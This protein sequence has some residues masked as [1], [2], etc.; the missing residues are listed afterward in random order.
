MVPGL[1]GA[2]RVS[3][4]WLWS[5]HNEH[6]VP[7][8]RLVLLASLRLS[9]GDFRAGM[10]F[11]VV[12]L[13]SLALGMVLVAKRGASTWRETDAFFP[14]ALLHLGHHANLLWAWQAQFVLS[15]VLAGGFLLLIVWGPSWPGPRKMIVAGVLLAGL[16]LCGANGLAL[17]PALSLWL[18]ASAAAQLIRRAPGGRRAGF[19]I[20]GVTAIAILPA[21][22][23]FWGYRAA[24][25]HAI[26]GGIA[27][28]L[29]TALQFL[30]LMLGPSATRLWPYSGLVVALLF[31]ASVGLLIGVV[32][33]RPTE[34]PRAL[35]LLAFLGGLSSLAVG[36]GWGRAGSSVLAGFEPRYVTLA[37]PLGCPLLLHLGPLRRHAGPEAAGPAR[38]AGDD[39]GRPLAERPGR[40]Q[41]GGKLAEAATRLERDVRSGM[42]STWSSS[43]PRPS[44]TRP[45]MS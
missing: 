10:I 21:A 5:Q 39:A 25:H 8:P 6:R 22:L 27:A 38:P 29:T 16:P 33:R 31:V 12:A 24:G 18:L 26:E 36:L 1:T 14:L 44:C 3:M 7:L 17:A 40:N 35:G 11:N 2:R 4:E 45:R 41:C 9:A 23:Y 19:L 37:S 20:L 28:T 15:T 42:P 13:G 34:R 30:S 43:T 32:V